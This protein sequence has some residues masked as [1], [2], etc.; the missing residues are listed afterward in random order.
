MYG[1]LSAI[2]AMGGVGSQTPGLHRGK[3]SRDNTSRR[4][5]SLE[6]NYITAPSKVTENIFGVLLEPFEKKQ[7]SETGVFFSTN[8]QG[9]Q[10]GHSW[11][12][13]GA[14]LGPS[15]GPL[16]AL[17]PSGNLSLKTL[18]LSRHSLSRRH[19]GRGRR[20]RSI[21]SH[22]PNAA[23][24]ALLLER[25]GLL[26]ERRSRAPLHLLLERRELRR[27]DGLYQLL[28]STKDVCSIETPW[29][30]TRRCRC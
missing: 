9:S 11:G 21:F 19:S 13:R 18:S 10:S 25:R 15:C 27:P 16:K 23:Q 29:C 1:D 28:T 2:A 30:R 8:P 24:L 5:S 7:F 17:G 22:R 6:Q 3:A 26:L 14:F 4:D 12:S 20:G